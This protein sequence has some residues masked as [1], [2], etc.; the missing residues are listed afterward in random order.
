[1]KQ[2]AKVLIIDNDGCHLLMTR[3]NH[4]TFLNDPDLP[5]GTI[6]EGE[7]VLEAALREVEEE[8]GILLYPTDVV[9][10]YTGDSYST[11]GTEHSLY[12]A[13]VAQRPIVTMSW[14]HSSYAWV[15][16]EEFLEQARTAND[17]YMHMV[18]DVISGATS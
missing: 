4:P 3:S 7:Q 5:G 9:H 16:Q 17:N 11:H 8:A 15:S 14:E 10:A 1:M 6:E 13:R 18:H 12:I 2:V